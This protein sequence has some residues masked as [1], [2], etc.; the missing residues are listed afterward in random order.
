MQPGRALAVV[1]FLCLAGGGVW[2]L[3]GGGGAP[4]PLERGS[5][6]REKPGKESPSLLPREGTVQGKGDGE[7]S[8]RPSGGKALR[9]KVLSPRD[10]RGGGILLAGRVLGPGGAG[11]PGA[12]VRLDRGSPVA[13]PFFF[14]TGKALAKTRTGPAGEW[15]ISLDRSGLKGRRSYQVTA[16]KAGYVPGRVRLTLEGR[17]KSLRAPDIQLRLGTQLWGRVL[18]GAGKPVAHASVSAQ[19]PGAFH[20][21]PVETD[22]R[23][24]YSFPG[25]PPGKLELTV[26]AEGF[27]LAYREVRVS[28]AAYPMQVDF[29]L[30]RGLSISGRV[31]DRKGRPV[32]GARVQLERFRGGG[33]VSMVWASA[34][35][36]VKTGPAGK[37][38]I[39]GL[40]EKGNFRLTVWARGFLGNTSKKVRPGAQGVLIVL[41][42]GAG[43]RGEVVDFQ[44]RPLSSFRVEAF[45]PMRGRFFPS[46]R[47]DGEK[48]GRFQVSGL[49]PGKW[50]FR[51]VKGG[52]LFSALQ[53]KTLRPGELC[54]LGVIRLPRPGSLVVTVLDGEGAPVPGARVTASPE[55][56]AGLGGR[57]P[58]GETGKEGI[59]RLEGLS[60]G[61]W[62]VQVE[63]GDYTSAEGGPFDLSPGGRIPVEI[64]LSR[65]GNLLVQV[66]ER[67][68]K[69]REGAS[70]GV[71]FRGKGEKRKGASFSLRTGPDGKAEKDHVPPGE[72][73]VRLQKAMGLT[74][75]GG[76]GEG[77]VVLPGRGG[78]GG[79]AWRIRVEEGKTATL[80]VTAPGR[81]K[82]HGVVRDVGG[83]AQGVEVRISPAG[84]PPIFGRTVRTGAAGT[85]TL[86]K[87]DPGAYVLS[88]GRPGCAAKSREKIDLSED[89][90]TLEKD[91]EIPSG[92]ILGRVV[93]AGGKPLSGLLVEVGGGGNVRSVRMSIAIRGSGRRA[94][95]FLAAPK[96]PQVRTGP[97]GRFRIE[98]VPAG[99]WSVA[100]KGRKDGK[101]LA[102]KK[103]TVRDGRETDA[104]DLEVRKE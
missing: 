28:P 4:L 69:P 31:L 32:K 79:P 7:R 61:S 55:Q 54:D 27:A 8:A 12:E 35:E 63:H 96:V 1:F 44:G 9:K 70:L 36:S 11:L 20:A 25:F 41:D 78:E 82:I 43:V 87:V 51:A 40:E 53:E 24:R 23:G 85:Y 74:F 68:G 83:P 22:E 16:L 50:A 15:K 84:A 73:E 26:D 99:T 100:V 29:F 94:A 59:C 58:K 102:S 95:P 72:Y 60:P 67:S 6:G 42:R 45:R 97:E 88:W 21:E 62:R 92:V 103:V 101:I 65:G 49:E 3:S 13:L 52:G 19:G 47:V 66:L 75:R 86:D 104:G 90:G 81:W 64:R 56:Q 48:D 5:G 33:N 77:M 57:G 17:E 98:E 46:K 76:F 93:D 37:F 91:L 14:V 18:D 80:R 71:T 10:G 2:F 89:G 38:T 39:G 30:T 34:E